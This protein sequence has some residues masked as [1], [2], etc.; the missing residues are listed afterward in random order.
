M[1]QAWLPLIPSGATAINDILSVYKK[2]NYWYYFC[3][4]HSVFFHAANDQRSF[5]LFTAQL[6]CQGQCRQIE[7][8]R[9]FGVSKNSVNR[10]VK[11]YRETGIN[12]FFSPRRKR[13]GTVITKEI[14]NQA[15][16]LFGS[17]YSR[18]EVAEELGIIKSTLRKAINQG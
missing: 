5:R 9:T 14:K 17:G 12:G 2:D 11:K 8:I 1:P 18:S 7:I 16:K 3:G 6:V 13:E 4:I 10:A 15:E